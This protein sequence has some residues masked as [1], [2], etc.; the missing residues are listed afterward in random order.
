MRGVQCVALA[1]ALA[2]SLGACGGAAPAGTTYAIRPDGKAKYDVSAD[3][4]KAVFE[5]LSQGR[6][7][8][9]QGDSDL[10]AETF[11]ALDANGDGAVTHAEWSRPVTPD[12]LNSYASAYRPFAAA[13]FDLAAKGRTTVNFGDLDMSLGQHPNRPEGLSLHAFKSVAPGGT[14]SNKA[15]ENYYPLLAGQGLEPRGFGSV[16]LGGYLKFAGFVGSE[17]LIHRPKKKNVGTPALLGYAFEEKTLI[18]AE[19][20]MAIKAWYI[21]AARPTTK[22]VVMVHGHGSNRSSWVQNPIE[23]KAIH[24]AGFNTVLIDLRH[25]GDSAGEFT[26]MALHEDNDVRAGVRYAQSKGN[27]AIGLMGNS[28]GGASVIHA[29]A[30]TPEVKAVWDDCAYS[31]FHL[32]VTSAAANLKVPFL[33]LVVPAILETANRRLGEDMSGGDPNIWIGKVAPRPIA[34][35]HGEKDN[36]IFAENSRI[37]F[38]SAM[39][40]KSLWIVPNAGHG[41]SSATAPA[42]YQTKVA[43]F[44]TDTL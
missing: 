8:I 41:N 37:N 21:S 11:K 12:Q 18:T 2:G 1:A 35:I 16:L 23:L 31:S 40:P 4:M 20:K 25:H 6:G 14:M 38:A 10:P 13:T 30:T 42:E 33:A 3:F 15:F 24:E 26:S 28:L 36:Y 39:E 5:R 44:F 32:A 9:R 29:A 19:D 17:F 43:K 34:I 27:T 7:Q 22:A